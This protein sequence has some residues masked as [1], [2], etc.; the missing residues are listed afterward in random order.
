MEEG[1]REMDG[2]RWRE[3]ERQG[4]GKEGCVIFMSMIGVLFCFPSS[5]RYCMRLVIERVASRP[6][7]GVYQSYI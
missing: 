3:G 1:G 2:G 5:G 4:T 6:R 7:L